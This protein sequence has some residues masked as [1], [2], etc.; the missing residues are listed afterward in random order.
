ML[1]IGCSHIAR[2]AKF[3]K[4]KYTPMKYQNALWRSR[5][6]GIGGGG[7][8]WWNLPK[9]LHGIDLPEDKQELGNLWEKLKNTNLNATNTVVGCGGNDC[10]DLDIASGAILEEEDRTMENKKK[11]IH[12]IMCEWLNS[13]QTYV[14]Q[15][16]YDI[17][18]A[19][20]ETEICYVPI[21][22]RP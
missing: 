3:A 5:Y 1:F 22:I 19:L 6:M 13:L 12:L 2:L 17:K 21:F 16:M 15:L 10:D 4:C 18:L 11:R 14:R 20:P 8:K 9:Y 7:P